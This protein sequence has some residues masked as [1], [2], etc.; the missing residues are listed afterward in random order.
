MINKITKY[1][2]LWNL[3]VVNAYLKDKNYTG[4]KKVNEIGGKVSL[5]NNWEVR[6]KY[7]FKIRSLIK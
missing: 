3:K 5:R 2:V 6:S 1:Y 4:R 7:V